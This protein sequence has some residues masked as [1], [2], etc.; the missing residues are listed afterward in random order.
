MTMQRVQ[1]TK[2]DRLRRARKDAGLSQE[3][4]AMELDVART[5]ISQYEND[6]GGIAAD[7]L[8]RW[9]E[10]TGASLDWIAWGESRPRES[11]PRPSHY[12]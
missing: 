11:N 7:R 4:M 5:T 12:E 9:A 2:G 6:G 1:T 8:I 3:Q 10:L